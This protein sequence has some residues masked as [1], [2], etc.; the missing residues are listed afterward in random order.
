[1]IATTP[2]P[3][4]QVD[5][6][7]SLLADRFISTTVGRVTLVFPAEWV[8][9]ILRLDRLAILELPFYNPLL[10]GI[11]NHNS[12][13]ISLVAAARLLHLESLSLPERLLVVRLNETAGNLANVGI[14]VDRAIGSMT[15][16]RLPPSLFAPALD[17]AAMVLLQPES[18]P[19]DIWQPQQ[20]RNLGR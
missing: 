9:E 20:W 11:I 19:A 14:I 13:V 4:S 18:V 17:P 7:Q 12:R 3:T 2:T 5:Y 8:A 15:R 16:D 6:S 10:V 1:M